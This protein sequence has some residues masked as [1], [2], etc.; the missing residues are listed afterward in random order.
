MYYIT[1]SFQQNVSRVYCETFDAHQKSPWAVHKMDFS[2]YTNSDKSLINN[3]E[4]SSKITHPPIPLYGA[5]RILPKYLLVA[6]VFLINT[7][8]LDPKLIKEV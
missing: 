8:C 5:K 3:P 2:V 6:V 4:K 7:F 1:G